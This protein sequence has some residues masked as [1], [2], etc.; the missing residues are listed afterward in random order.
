MKNMSR[1]V[2]VI[3]LGGASASAQAGLLGSTVDLRFLSPDI[4]TTVEDLG[5]QI[6][7]PGVEYPTSGFLG[8]SVDI[9]D[10]GMLVTNLISARY[11]FGI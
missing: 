7:G 9:S 1:L 5:N 2:V 4:G 11:I 6:V 10:T 3:A 8:F